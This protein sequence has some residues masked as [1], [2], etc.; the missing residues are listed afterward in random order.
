MSERVSGE[1]TRQIPWCN[2]EVEWTEFVGGHDLRSV[3][4]VGKLELQFVVQ[5]GPK[6]KVVCKYDTAWI[7]RVE[8]GEWSL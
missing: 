3:L 5:F 6:R 8:S 1:H 2:S 4:Q 7:E